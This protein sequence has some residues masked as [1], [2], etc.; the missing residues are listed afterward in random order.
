MTVSSQNLRE[1]RGGLLLNLLL[2][3]HVQRVPL[4]REC[5]RNFLHEGFCRNSEFG[6]DNLKKV[7]HAYT[8]TLV[9]HMFFQ[10]GQT[11][12]Q[13]FCGTMLNCNNLFPNGVVKATSITP[14]FQLSFASDAIENFDQAFFFLR[15]WRQH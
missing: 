5:S 3:Q 15:V 10:C 7:S 6:K 12:D 4:T 11:G 1:T 9:P 14:T 8:L 2:C 13:R